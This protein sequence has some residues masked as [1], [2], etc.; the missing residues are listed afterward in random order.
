MKIKHLKWA[1]PLALFLVVFT[2]AC[3]QQEGIG[4]SSHIKGKIRVNYYNDD[5][6]LLLSDQPEAARDEDVFLIFGNDSVIGDDMT[7]SNTGNFEFNY[8]WPGNYKLFYYSDDTTGLSD[9][10]VPVVKNITLAKGETLV[11]DELMI[12]KKL[13]W[14]E[15][16]SSIKG[17][18]M[19]INYLNS[20]VYPNLKIKDITPAQE[21]EI[22]I[23]Y[24]N[25]PFYDE[26]IRT[27]GD[28]TFMFRNLIKGKY[29]IFLY[30]EDV[31]GGTAMVVKNTAFEIK[32]N[33]SADSI[34]YDDGIAESDT[35]YI[36]KL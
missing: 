16:T 25:H 29:K 24:G 3:T 7:T 11:L 34:S 4:G 33:N 8:L 35:I 28:G 30:S 6:S 19:V 21:Q 1:L 18:V 23:T 12:K 13:K 27:S 2:V 15:G 31:A 26:R 9:D 14:N 10:K 17:T 20:S 32:Q 22:Y 5:F 36:E